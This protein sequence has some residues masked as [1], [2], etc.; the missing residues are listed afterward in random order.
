MSIDRAA[1]KNPAASW[2]SCKSCFGFRS[3]RTLMSIDAQPAHGKKVRRT[4][5]SI[6]S[7]LTVGRG[8]VPRQRRSHRRAESPDPDPFA[9]WRSRATGACLARPRQSRGTGPRA[10]GPQHLPLYRRARACPS[11]CPRHAGKLFAIRRSRTTG[12]APLCRSRSPDPDL[13]REQACPSRDGRRKKT[14]CQVRKSLMSHENNFLKINLTFRF[15]NG[16]LYNTQS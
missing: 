15:F 14:R 11:P 10:T 8:P 12:A 6:D 7:G 1:K 13:F 5:M 4:L 3:V 16:I 2:I 9:I